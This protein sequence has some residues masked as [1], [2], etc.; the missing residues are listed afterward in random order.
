MAYDNSDLFG[1]IM[2]RALQLYH[3]DPLPTL[4]GFLFANLF[5]SFRSEHGNYSLHNVIEY[6]YDHVD[7]KTGN[8]VI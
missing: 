8:L 4:A 3:V 1:V 6:V 5:A 2:C 7:Q